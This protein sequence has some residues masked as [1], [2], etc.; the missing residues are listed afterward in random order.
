M[1]KLLLAS[2]LVSGPTLAAGS[3]VVGSTADIP[4]SHHADDS[5]GW[6]V[7]LGAGAVNA[8]EFDGV[9][10][11]ETNAVPLIKVNYN[12]RFYIEFNK[13]GWWAW[14]PD[15]TGFSLGLVAQSRKG[16]DKGDGPIPNFEVD[17]TALA[18]IR[19][20][21]INGRFAIHG[22]VLGSSESDSGGEAHI[23]A[24]YTFIASPKGTLSAMVQAETLSEDAV[25]YFYYAETDAGADSATN[26][27]LGVIGTYNFSKKWT[28]IGGVKVTS[29]DDPISDAPGVTEDSSTKAVL[30]LM[31]NF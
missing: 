9:D 8:P 19:A 23:T 22:A 21:W 11:T 12:H 30:G 18:G 16:Y 29:L 26:L 20:R 13:I 27:S 4:A 7:S 28:M 5:S 31:Y 14:K 2:L 1:K 15:D 6:Q 3:G 17:D 25:D 10:D 24:S